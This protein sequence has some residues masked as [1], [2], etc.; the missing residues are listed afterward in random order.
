MTWY[1]QF[2]SLVTS[3]ISVQEQLKRHFLMQAF[4]EREQKGTICST[5]LTTLKQ[6]QTNKKTKHT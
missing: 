6:N 3:I 5:A 4:E 1:L 2:K